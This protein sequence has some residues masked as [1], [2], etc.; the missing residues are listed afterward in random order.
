MIAMLEN[1]LDVREVITHRMPV[2]GFR[3]GFE[4]MSRKFGQDRSRLT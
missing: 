1:G 3:K 4:I 2:D